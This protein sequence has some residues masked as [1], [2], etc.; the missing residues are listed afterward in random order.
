MTTLDTLIQEARAEEAAMDPTPLIPGDPPDPLGVDGADVKV[1][2]PFIAHGHAECHVRLAG[3]P[4]GNYAYCRRPKGHDPRHPHVETDKRSAAMNG[5]VVW[6]WGKGEAPVVEVAEEVT[7]PEDAKLESYEVGAFASYRNKRRVLQILSRPRNKDLEVEVLDLT[8][9]RMMKIRKEHLV[10]RRDD[11]PPIT[12]EQFEWMG[13]FLAERRR[14]ALEVA[15]RELGN[16][17]WNRATMNESLELLDIAPLPAKY[18]GSAEISIRFEF[19]EG[20][21]VD[22]AQARRLVEKALVREHEGVKVTGISSWYG[23]EPRE[24]AG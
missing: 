6:V 22:R 5:E 9:Q 14:K 10:P 2:D 1:G 21:T 18:G 11:D 16:G 20:V 4:I 3:A 19:P 13:K 8:H 15:K 24:I 12:P 7:D 23:G 17:R